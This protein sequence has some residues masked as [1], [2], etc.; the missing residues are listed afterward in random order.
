MKLLF[1]SSQLIFS[2]GFF[3]AEF[4]CDAMFLDPQIGQALLCHTGSIK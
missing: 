2:A 1:A 4:G 3:A